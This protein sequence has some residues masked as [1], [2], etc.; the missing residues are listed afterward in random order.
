MRVERNTSAQEGS[1][2]TK[3][4]H[5]RLAPRYREVDTDE[6]QEI[7]KEGDSGAGDFVFSKRGK[8]KG[9]ITKGEGSR[10]KTKPRPHAPYVS[11]SRPTR[12]FR[13]LK[14]SVGLA[15]AICPETP[16]RLVVTFPTQQ[17]SSKDP[18]F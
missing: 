13:P 5:D 16:E 17:K 11:Q 10:R 12:A 1:R 6:E 15:H 4:R 8:G 3:A 2:R 9:I 14:N 18:S 7:E